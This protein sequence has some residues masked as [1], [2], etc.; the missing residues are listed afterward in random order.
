MSGPKVKGG[1][2]NSIKVE[3]YDGVKMEKRNAINKILQLELFQPH[4]S[5]K[6]IEFVFFS[7]YI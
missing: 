6:D 1:K 7:P 3:R 4:R 5:G 2:R